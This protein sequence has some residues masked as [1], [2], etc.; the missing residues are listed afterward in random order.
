MTKITRTYEYARA[1]FDPAAAM[2]MSGLDY[3][4]AL[5]AGQIGAQPSIS[6]T[7]GMSPARDLAYGKVAFEAEPGD[8]LLNPMGTVHGGFAATIMDSALGISVHT[9]LEP[10][11]GFT[12]AE[13]K[14]NYTRAI[15]SDGGKLRAEGEV[16]HRGRRMATA[17][18]RLIGVGDDKL[19]AHGST[20]C[21][22]FPLDGTVA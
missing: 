6:A 15:R 22:L 9:T 21:F 13:L 14:I 10:G 1:T 3:M 12:T 20:T 11:W 4:R 17:E 2:R 18:A 8:W 16:I 5:A 7:M 19:Y